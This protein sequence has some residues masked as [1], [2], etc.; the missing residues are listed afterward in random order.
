VWQDDT[1]ILKRYAAAGAERSRWPRMRLL[2]V[3]ISQIL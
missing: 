3:R 2:T 1:S